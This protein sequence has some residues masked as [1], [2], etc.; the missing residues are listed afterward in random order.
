MS[1][2]GVPF[3]LLEAGNIEQLFLKLS[4]LP[5][6]TIDSPTDY[7]QLALTVG[8]TF[9]GGI[10]PALIAWRT[11]HVNAKNVKKERQE[12][13]RFLQAERAKQQIFMMSERAS[14]IASLK[15]DRELQTSI[16]QRTINAQV[17]SVNRQNWINELRSLFA[18]FCSSGFSFYNA[19]CDYLIATIKLEGAGKI[20]NEATD[21]LSLKDMMN[22]IIQDHQMELARVRKEQI[23]LERI[24]YTILLMLNQ[25]EPDNSAIGDI[26]SDI[27][28][29]CLTLKVNESGEFINRGGS[30]DVIIKKTNELLIAGQII[31][32][33]EWERVKSGL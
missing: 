9:L 24:K 23:D 16:A 18:S 26:M 32:K 6:L 12:Q 14:Q 33:K 7:N 15:E 25:N 11:F 27:I 20:F 31:L 1:W 10:I 5:K 13:Q 28:L 8:A 4:E 3:K 17:V 21:K 2:Q 22:E 19:R 30:Y 29:A